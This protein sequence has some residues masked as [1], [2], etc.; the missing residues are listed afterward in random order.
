MSLSG[1]KR[2]LSH[3]CEGSCKVGLVGLVAILAAS[4]TGCNLTVHRVD[5]LSKGRLGPPV[6]T[7]P[8]A[9]EVLADTTESAQPEEPVVGD[10]ADVSV[11]QGDAEVAQFGAEQGA[12]ETKIAPEIKKPASNSEDSPDSSQVTEGRPS[13]N[14]RRRSAFYGPLR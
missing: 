14:E 11:P 6:A 5:G 8:Q 13:K 7:Q 9:A 4:S 1:F 12:V 10:I 3:Y 2:L